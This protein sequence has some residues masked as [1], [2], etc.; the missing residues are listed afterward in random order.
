MPIEDRRHP[1]IVAQPSGRARPGRA[2]EFSN[3]LYFCHCS[4]PLRSSLRYP[5]GSSQGMGPLMLAAPVWA[6]TASLALAGA[7]PGRAVGRDGTGP[8]A[9]TGAGPGLAPGRDWRR[10]GTGAGGRRRK[11]EPGQA[12]AVVSGTGGKGCARA[13]S[14]GS[15]TGRSR[16]TAGRG[17]GADRRGPRTRPRR[18]MDWWSA[19]EGGQKR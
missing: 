9:G 7:G 1:A 2:P 13:P 5:A 4:L 10:A 3:Q 16:R 17:P 6:A 8:R 15:A 14:V 12:A 19:W 11:R 18:P